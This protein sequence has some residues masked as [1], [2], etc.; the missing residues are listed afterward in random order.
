MSDARREP[1][2]PIDEFQLWAQAE[3]ARADAER[4]HQ[5]IQLAP[6]PLHAR[7]GRP[8]R[9]CPVFPRWLVPVPRWRR[10]SSGCRDEPLPGFHGS[11][12]RMLGT[13]VKLDQIYP[14]VLR[15]TLGVR[16]QTRNSMSE[17][18]CED[19]TLLKAALLTA[20]FLTGAMGAAFVGGLLQF[21][22]D[23]K[24]WVLYMRN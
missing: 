3:L 1:L 18:S 9:G 11:A 23:N 19:R 15:G 5:E 20:V 14:A 10:S 21:H 24:N 7:P 12:G 4:K 2:S 13:P 8:M 6:R 17:G 16:E 22:Q